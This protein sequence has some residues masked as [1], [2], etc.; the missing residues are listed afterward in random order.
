MCVGAF[1]HCA[2]RRLV[3]RLAPGGI[4]APV[5]HAQ[6]GRRSNQRPSR[7]R[8]HQRSR[9]CQPHGLLPPRRPHLPRLHVCRAIK[10]L[11]DLRPPKGQRRGRGLGP[12][13]A[14][15]GGRAAASWGHMTA[16]IGLTARERALCLAAAAA[17][18]ALVRAWDRLVAPALF[19]RRQRRRALAAGEPCVLDTAVSTVALFRRG[20]VALMN[21]D[22]AGAGLPGYAVDYVKKLLIARGADQAFRTKV[23]L[24][25][26]KKVM[27][28][29]QK[30]L[31]EIEANLSVFAAV[32]YCGPQETDKDKRKAA[33]RLAKELD[34]CRGKRPLGFRV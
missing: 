34:E 28:H 12:S 5:V 33:A 10:I 21:K 31:E 17:A 4:R 23:E 2:A 22:L 11:C 1:V 27:V 18:V 14:R 24:V 9:V 30:H 6:R 15:Q 8:P 20:G 16:G 32:T 13:E 3:R 29:M 7:K 19:A 25:N 26:Y